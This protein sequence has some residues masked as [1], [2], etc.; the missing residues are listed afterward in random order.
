MPRKTAAGRCRWRWRGSFNEAAARCRGKLVAVRRP[1][2][3]PGASMRP[4]PDAAEN[5]RLDHHAARRGRASMRPRPDAAENAALRGAEPAAIEVA[6]MR[7]R[8]DAAENARG[9]ARRAPV[10]RCFNEAAARCRG[11]PAELHV[12]PAAERASM[13]P[14]PDAAENLPRFVLAPRPQPASMRCQMQNWQLATACLSR[15]VV[16]LLPIVLSLLLGIG[17]AIQ[18][19]SQCI[20]EQHTVHLTL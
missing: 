7:P 6:S 11:K 9:A 5:P 13:R 17:I 10:D 1:P 16:L 8:P 15:R 18:Y 2:C 4:R 12:A 19:I 20:L 3:S 14:R